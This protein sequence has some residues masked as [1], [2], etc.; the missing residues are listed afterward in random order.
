MTRY[1]RVAEKAY[2]QYGTGNISPAAI[3]AD[4]NNRRTYGSRSNVFRLDESLNNLEREKTLN[5][6][7][8]RIKA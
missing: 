6:I 3:I 8:I 5:D 2:E 7:V 4:C 1:F